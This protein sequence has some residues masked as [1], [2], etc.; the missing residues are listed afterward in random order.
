LPKRR[1]LNAQTFPNWF[2]RSTH[3]ASVGVGGRARSDPQRFHGR[4]WVSHKIGVG[5]R[6]DEKLFPCAWSW[7]SCGGARACPLF[8]I[9]HVVTLQ[10]ST[11]Q[12]LRLA[13]CIDREEVLWVEGGAKHSTQLA[14]GMVESGEGSPAWSLS[15]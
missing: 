2:P 9:A 11:S 8:G 7:L 5:I 15:R 4:V 14:V 1:R 10:P 13:Q 12:M 3:R 6:W